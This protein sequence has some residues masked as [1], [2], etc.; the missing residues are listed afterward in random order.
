MLWQLNGP[1]KFDMYSAGIT[2][3]QMAFPP[4]RNDNG[5]VAFNKV[6]GEQH[7]WDLNSWR[8]SIEKRGG[9][10]WM[11]GL[12][13]LDALN[14]GGLDLAVKLIQKN[15][16]DRITAS[17]ALA[18][19]WFDSS[20]L[21]AVTSTVETFGRAAAKVADPG[22]GWLMNQIARSG[23]SEAGGFTEAQLKEELENLSYGNSNKTE[24]QPRTSNTISWW[25]GRQK[26]AQ[27][28][29]RERRSQIESRLRLAGRKAKKTV[30]EGRE[31]FQKSLGV[32]KLPFWK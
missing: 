9:K 28:Q 31:K 12:Q 20:L 19:P 14:G 11:E 25:Q 10:D 13:T 24:P 23:T 1:D 5:L 17:A 8:R 3:L 26:A 18:H 4:L 30:A 15:P 7:N 22:D 29:M 6:L 21:A 32:A 2:L 27:D 16:R